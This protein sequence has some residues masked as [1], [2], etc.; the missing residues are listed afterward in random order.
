MVLVVLLGLA[1]VIVAALAGMIAF[2]TGDPPPPLASIGAP[3]E[4]V[5]F[6]DLPA[7][8]RVAAR[9]GSRIAFRRWPISPP[10]EPKG[11]TKLVVVAI[12]GSS[13]TSASLHPL[14]KALRAQGIPVYAP[15]IRGHGG[16]GVRGD[17]DHAGQLDDDL[18][19]FAAAAR[20]RARFWA[21]VRRAHF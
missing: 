14:A 15:D 17:I 11:A 19:D 5:D 16:T 18:A 12:H 4:R 9:D 13:A 21:S 20:R 7:V 3:F 10:E 8:E 1:I 2:G 6:R